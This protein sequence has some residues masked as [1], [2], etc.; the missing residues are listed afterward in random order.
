MS[1]SQTCRQF[2]A[3]EKCKSHDVIKQLPVIVT[4]LALCLGAGQAAFA[5]EIWGYMPVS[6]SVGDNLF[7]NTLDFTAGTG[8]DNTLDNITVG[9]DWGNVIPEGTTVELWDPASGQYSAPSTFSNSTGHWSVN[10]TLLCGQGAKLHA[11]SAF[12][13]EFVG[14]FQKALWDGTGKVTQGGVDLSDPNAVTFVAPPPM[15]VPGVYLLSCVVPWGAPADTTFQ[16]VV[17][18]DPLVGETVRRLDPATQ[19]YS[20]TTFEGS[21]W[22]H[23]VPGINSG[24]GESAFFTLMPLSGDANGDGHVDINDLNVVLT[25]YDQTAGMNWST[26]DFNSDG[27]VD[28]NDLN[29]VLTNYDHS[30]GASTAGVAAVPEPSTIVLLGMAAAG[31][32]AVALRRV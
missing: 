17:G 20:T 24:G 3:M 2:V 5:D 26:G 15:N 18:R 30:L 32:L 4:A 29:R 19:T 28:I 25:N 7:C 1:K 11:P 10:Y 23:G 14:Y 21:S 12:D 6:F 22:N 31:L 13:N 27:K 9:N 8:S 16:M